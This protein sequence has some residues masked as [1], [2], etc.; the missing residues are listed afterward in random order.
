[1][2]KILLLLFVFICLV[3]CAEQS[4]VVI[5]GKDTY[6]VSRQAATGFPGLGNLKAESLR[7]ANQYCV[8]QGKLMQ[9]INTYETNPPYVFGNYPRVE[10][11]FMCLDANDPELKRPKLLKEADTVIKIKEK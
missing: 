5:L 8:E 10:I 2:Q 3:G 11:Q 4:G 9:T 6:M 7:E 1:M